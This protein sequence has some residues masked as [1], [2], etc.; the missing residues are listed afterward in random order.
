M[1]SEP[2]ALDN[3]PPSVFFR[4]VLTKCRKV[5][6]GLGVLV[7][8]TAVALGGRAMLAA[9]AQSLTVRPE[10]PP[11]V[12]VRAHR[13]TSEVVASALTYGGV[14]KEFEKAEISFRV[15]GRVERLL[16]LNGPT[17]RDHAIHEGDTVASGIALAELD[18]ADYERNRASAIEKLATA[19]ARSAQLES[20]ASLAQSDFRRIEQLRKR[21][22]TSDSELDTARTKQVSTSLVA[23]AARREIELARIALA[24]AEADLSYCTLK[25]PFTQGTVAA[26]YVDVGQQ[27]T[28]NQKAF[29]LLDLSSVVVT[30]GVPDTLVGRL[31]IGQHVD[32]TCDA[33]PGER[34][35]AV[36][37][38]ISSAAD[39][40]TRTYDV[41]ARIDEPRGL[42]PGMIAAVEFRREVRAHLLPLTA[43][44]PTDSGD[45][46]RV[47]RVAEEQ[48]R[49]VVRAEPIAFD[50]V[51][52]NRVAV[53][54]DSTAHL[55][56][57]DLVVVTGTHK[58]YDGMAVELE[59]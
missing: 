24:Q 37:H 44:V 7:I 47:Y 31:S 49:M 14:V 27:V 11:P 32:V 42:R 59:E 8:V 57:G 40:Q 29:L 2:S 15:G 45:G 1:S 58:L 22:A 3:A 19:E 9:R 51:L 18:L 53:R 30:I 55:Q 26:R 36:L 50:D 28:A 33:L 12:K 5:T 16:R 54:L 13:L 35:A 10:A 56:P 17:G 41:E 20:E 34:F 4:R 6:V 25:S 38:K 43:I 46:Y 23:T 21:N 52:D 48:G 39:P